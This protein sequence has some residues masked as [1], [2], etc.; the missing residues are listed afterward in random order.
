MFHV[1][2]LAHCPRRTWIIAYSY[3]I[4]FYSRLASSFAAAYFFL[5][6][7][8]LLSSILKAAYVFWDFYLW[9]VCCS[10]LFCFIKI[11][12]VLWWYGK[13]LSSILCFKILRNPW[14]SRLTWIFC[15]FIYGAKNKDLG[16]C[17]ISFSFF[18]YEVFM[19]YIF[20]IINTS[21]LSMKVILFSL[22]F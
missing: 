22:W 8:I 13:F 15:K 5:L 4:N 7:L 19:C 12:S 2:A 11:I 3:L 10:C 9:L 17:L 1:R 21:F 16:K 6:T 14:I 18:H 20:N